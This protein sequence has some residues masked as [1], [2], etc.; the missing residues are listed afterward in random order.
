[1]SPT[2]ARPRPTQ[3]HLRL[4]LGG[5]HEGIELSLEAKVPDEALEKRAVHLGFSDEQELSEQAEAYA[6]FLIDAIEGHQALF[7]R[8]DGVEECCW[9]I[10]EAALRS[11]WPAIGYAPGPE[12]F[13]GRRPDRPGRQMAR[14]PG[15]L[16]NAAETRSHSPRTATTPCW[17]DDRVRRDLSAAIDGAVHLFYQRRSGR[18]RRGDVG[19]GGSGPGHPTRRTP[20]SAGEPRS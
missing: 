19:G 14:S 13:G 15:R 17:D 5:G 4:R 16:V 11:N 12:P 8:L 6:R 18:T 3:N 2:R 9:R 7:A 10:V 1:M 20:S